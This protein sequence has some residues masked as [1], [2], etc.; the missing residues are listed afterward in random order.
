VRTIPNI[1]HFQC[2]A[3][4]TFLLKAD[5]TTVLTVIV[6]H[7]QKV[8]GNSLLGFTKGKWYVN[9]LVSY[10][11]EMTGSVEEGKSIMPYPLTLAWSVTQPPTVCH[12]APGVR[13][14]K[15]R[16]G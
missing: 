12:S 3:V 16:F 9:N 4:F 5:D 8:S 10:R 2:L 15:V 7:G 11:D 13:P 6:L 14:I 1:Y